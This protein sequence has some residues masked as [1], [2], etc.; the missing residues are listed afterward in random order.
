[1]PQQARPGHAL[2][3]AITA[4]IIVIGTNAFTQTTAPTNSLPNPYNS[5]ENWAKL[6]DGR[7]WG[8]TSAVDIDRDGSSVWVGERCGAFAPPSAMRETLAA[9]K[10]FACQGSTL[11]PILKF[12]ATGKLVKSFGAGMLIFPHG[13]HVDR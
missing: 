7:T 8:S 9:G 5:I 10:P 6:P 3:F 2:A 4:A 13:L 11:D 12:D 1:M